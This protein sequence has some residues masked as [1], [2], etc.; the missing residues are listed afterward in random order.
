MNGA[1][2]LSWQDAL[3]KVV[4]SPDQDQVRPSDRGLTNV[5]AFLMEKVERLGELEWVRQQ[6]LWWMDT[7]GYV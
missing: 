1:A 4:G 5:G 6:V 3:D 7:G 2:A